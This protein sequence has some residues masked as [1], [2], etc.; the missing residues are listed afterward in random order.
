MFKVNTDW[1]FDST[2]G[3]MNVILKA[4]GLSQNVSLGSAPFNINPLSTYYSRVNSNIPPCEFNEAVFQWNH[5]GNLK[6][7]KLQ[8]VWISPRH[9]DPK[10]QPNPNQFAK[11]FCVSGFITSGVP[12]PM[13]QC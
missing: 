12:R 10:K 8:S 4:P 9:P 13:F 1:G 3:Y 5:Q 2:V 6:N 7:I 11:N